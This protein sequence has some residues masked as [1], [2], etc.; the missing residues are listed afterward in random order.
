MDRQLK[1]RKQARKNKARRAR[2][3]SDASSPT[4]SAP[5]AGG[6]LKVREACQYLGGIHPS[7]L[8]RLA[9]RGL[10][11]PN[12]MFRHTLYTRAELDRVLKEGQV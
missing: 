5:A 10:I 4:G 8:R 2:K 3:G 9:Q 11:R 1:E 6:A 7:T 12:R